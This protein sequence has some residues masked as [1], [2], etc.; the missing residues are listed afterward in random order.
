M[1]K[2]ID[3][4]LFKPV[5]HVIYLDLFYDRIISKLTKN[6]NWTK[7][8]MIKYILYDWVN[9]NHDLLKKDYNIN[10]KDIMEGIRQEKLNWKR[11]LEKEKKIT[12]FNQIIQQ[13]IQKLVKYSEFFEEIEIDIL[14]KQLEISRRI[15]RDIIIRH[16]L[17]LEQLSVKLRIKGKLIIK[18]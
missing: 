5:D 1:P 8:E 3:K 4:L 7:S 12:E 17:Q 6:H 18:E 9:N 16:N 2:K 15:L 11:I 13:S 14:A 10:F